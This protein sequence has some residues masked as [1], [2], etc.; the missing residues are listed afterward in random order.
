M[1]ELLEQLIDYLKGI[2]IKRR[3]IIISTWLICP[4]GWYMVSSMPD[5]YESNARVYV[6]TQSLLRP[7]LKG[8]TVETNPETQI[9][10]MV[11]TFL[12]Q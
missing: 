2:W 6:D 4:L 10:L 3:Y 8:L 9:R 11:K 7:L 5:V 12:K 1:Q